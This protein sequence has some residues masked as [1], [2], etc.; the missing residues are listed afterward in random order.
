M[1]IAVETTESC[2]K[3]IIKSERTHLSIWDIDDT[4][5]SHPENT[6]RIRVVKKNTKEYLKRDGKFVTMSTAEFA[7]PIRQKKIIGSDGILTDSE[8]FVDFRSSAIFVKH[9]NIIE[10]NVIKAREEYKKTDTFFIM[11][12]AR[13]NMDDPNVFLDYFKRHGLNMN[14]KTKSGNARKDVHAHLLRAGSLT[15]LGGGAAKKKV[16]LEILEAVPSI[17]SV[18][19]YDDAADNIAHFKRIRIKNR[20][21]DLRAFPIESTE[22]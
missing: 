22:I 12:T 1:G 9:A 7:D 14:T 18:D 15:T 20:K 2:I 11:L 16:I 17:K 5:V 4:L 21:L 6:T 13:G 19:F 3:N 8:S 10:K